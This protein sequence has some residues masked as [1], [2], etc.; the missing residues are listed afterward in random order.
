MVTLQRKKQHKKDTNGPCTGR[1]RNNVPQLLAVSS[2]MTAK[3]PATDERSPNERKAYKRKH[4]STE[5]TYSL[6]PASSPKA[7]RESFH[8]ATQVTTSLSLSLSLLYVVDP[9]K[10]VRGSRRKKRQQQR[11]ARGHSPRMSKKA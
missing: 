6:F 8:A 1:L 5:S 11:S 2:E 7:R 10:G 3:A 9:R 4:G